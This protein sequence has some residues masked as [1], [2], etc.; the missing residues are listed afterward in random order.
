MRPLTRLLLALA[1]ALPGTAGWVPAAPG[2]LEV[3]DVPLGAEAIAFASHRWQGRPA[4]SVV[5]RTAPQQGPARQTLH[6]VTADAAGAR[7]VGRWALPERARHVEPLALPGGAGGWLVL[8]A[9]RWLLAQV[10]GDALRLVELCACRTVYAGGGAPDPERHRFVHDLDG[11]GI[12]EVLLPFLTH[13]EAYRVTPFFLAL[14]PLWRARWLPAGTPLPALEGGGRSPRVPP[15]AVGDVD[16]T[17]GAELIIRDDKRLLIAALPEPAPARLR[18]DARKQRLLS[19]TA[20][21]DPPP[22]ALLQAL[23]RLDGRDFASAAALLNALNQ[24]TT[25]AEMGAWGPF[26][27]AVLRVARD[28]IAVSTPYVVP[29]P[30][31]PDPGEDDRMLVLGQ[32]DMDG[33]GVL[34]LLHAHLQDYGSVLN[35]QN[36]LRWYRGEVEDGRLRFAKPTTA[37]RS[38]AGSFAELFEPQVSGLPP[39]ALLMATTEV[40]FGS[41]MS[42]LATQRVTLTAS[43]YPWRHG[44]LRGRPTDRRELTYH[45]LK[46]DGRRAMFLFADLNGDGWR[47]Y[48]LNLEQGLLNVYL[49]AEAAPVLNREAFRQG[50]LRLPSKPERVLVT[51]LDQDDREDLVLRYREKYHGALGRSLRIVRLPPKR[52]AAY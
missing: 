43:I 50:G 12:H 34:D 2:P 8:A 28:R 21:A 5:T 29:L 41:I 26:L 35:Q 48:V 31:L 15:F 37:L 40:S 13:L 39:L 51:D 42:A 33:D 38:D 17:G 24:R 16:G 32:Q 1:L 11:D 20:G 30:A 6:L 4:V 7:E 14:E 46:A 19:A 49:S 36:L 18:L 25:P 22:E 27:P 9:G 10:Q 23:R 47:D 3:L 45:D 52:E 44:A